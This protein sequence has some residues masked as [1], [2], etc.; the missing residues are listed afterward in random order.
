MDVIALAWIA[1]QSRFNGA[2]IVAFGFPL[3]CWR[4]PERWV[5]ARARVL[6]AAT[7]HRAL[8]FFRFLHAYSASMRAARFSL[9]PATG[10]SFQSFRCSAFPSLSRFVSLSVTFLLLF[11]FS[12]P[13]ACLPALSVCLSV[14]LSVCLSICLSVYLSICPLACQPASFSFR[15]FSLSVSLQPVCV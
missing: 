3:D 6:R 7:A 14:R 8:P 15:S 4:V 2:L 1:L 11:P 5:D 9:S 10:E 12:F 13:F